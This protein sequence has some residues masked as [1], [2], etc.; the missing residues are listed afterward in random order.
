MPRQMCR[1]I[2]AGVSRGDADGY[3]ARGNRVRDRGSHSHRGTK[4]NGMDRNRLRATYDARAE[5]Y[6]RTIGRGERM[7]LGDFRRIFAAELRGE[8]LEIAIGTGLNLP[9]YPPAV[10]GSVGVDLSRG[11][12]EQARQRAEV[13]E[14]SVTLLQMDAQRLAF[15]DD[16]FETVAISLAL[17]TVPD[18]VRV[19]Q[20]AARVCRP[21]GRVVLLE[22]VLSPVLP[23]AWAQRLVSPV[24]ERLIGCHL[25]RTTIATV[26][27]LD[28]AV[29]AERSRLGGIVRV[30]IATPP[31]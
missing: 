1:G 9:F 15:P 26:R 17:C 29:H 23:I 13:L 30:V 6:D 22:H 2:G 25:D 7:L 12:L 16:T 20:E 3:H 31:S 28:F 14:R 19:L 8:T 24:Q 21:G 5:T 27:A 11:M 4:G 18:P 10:A